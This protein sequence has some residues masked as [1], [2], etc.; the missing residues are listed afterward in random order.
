MSES[1]KVV[2]QIPQ[3]DPSIRSLDSYG[4]DLFGLHG[5]VLKSEYMFDPG[6]DPAFA[7]VLKVLRCGELFVPA[8]LVV[9]PAANPPVVEVFL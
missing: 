1:S 2:D 4:T 8:T 7:A 5:V 3:S 6:P 9:N